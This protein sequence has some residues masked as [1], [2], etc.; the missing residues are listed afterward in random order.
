MSAGEAELGAWLTIIMGEYQEMPGLQLTK[1]QVL[2]L[3][4]LAPSV[5]DRVLER[6]QAEHFL[7]VTPGGCYVLAERVKLP[8]VGER[9]LQHGKGATC[10]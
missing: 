4:G 9:S 8:P 5:G 10:E 2:R 1:S 6:L 3:W 7:R